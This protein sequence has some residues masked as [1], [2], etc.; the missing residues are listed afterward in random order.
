MFFSAEKQL[1]RDSRRST[2]RARVDL[3]VDEAGAVFLHTQGNSK[4]QRKSLEARYPQ[5]SRISRE[6]IM[7]LAEDA[8]TTGIGGP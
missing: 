5:F 4:P 6:E 7:R 3:Q 2:G 8:D 1:N